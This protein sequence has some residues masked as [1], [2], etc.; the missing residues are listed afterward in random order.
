MPTNTILSTSTTS[1]MSSVKECKMKSINDLDAN[2]ADE[3]GVCDLDSKQMLVNSMSASTSSSLS[4]SFSP[5]QT[6][7]SKVMRND[8]TV[9]NGTSDL[10]ASSSSN[11][12]SLSASSFGKSATTAAAVDSNAIIDSSKTNSN[13]LN[14]DE[15]INND[16][17]IINDIVS[18]PNDDLDILIKMERANKLDSNFFSLKNKFLL[19]IYFSNPIELSK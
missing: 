16:S 12:S 11:S 9:N 13:S 15:T 7:G 2:G 1:D 4:N 6:N 18:L 3:S 5:E 8:S 14:H 10:L 17:S 19:L